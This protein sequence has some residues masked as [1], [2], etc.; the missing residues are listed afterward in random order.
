MVII[1]V[2]FYKPWYYTAS[3][4]AIGF[5]G[6]WYPI[7]GILAIVYQVGQLIFNVRIFPV[8]GTIKPGN[9]IHHTFIKL[10]EIAIGYAIGS[11]IK[12]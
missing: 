11:V 1:M 8:E 3:H 4:V 6:V 12:K 10:S 5:I 2:H 9:S 7:I